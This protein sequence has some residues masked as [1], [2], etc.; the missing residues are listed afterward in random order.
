[1]IFLGRFVDILMYGSPETIDK[2]LHSMAHFLPVG[3]KI[4]ARKTKNAVLIFQQSLEKKGFQQ[5][6]Q[7]FYIHSK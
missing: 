1:L 4:T 2:N 3:E 7:H 6:K 5:H